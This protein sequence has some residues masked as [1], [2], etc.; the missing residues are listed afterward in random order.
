M[1]Y[2]CGFE[3]LPSNGGD[4]NRVEKLGENMKPW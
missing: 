4:R 3:K 2:Q 1:D